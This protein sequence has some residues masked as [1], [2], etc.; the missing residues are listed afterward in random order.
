MSSVPSKRPLFRQEV[1]AF[2]QLDR[3]WG[4]VVPLQPMRTRVMVW[5]VIAA[6]AA[7]LVFVCLAKYARK[8]TAMGY[9][10]PAAGTAR[11]F[12]QQP[13]IVSARYVEQ[14]QLVQEGDPL[15]AV[16]TT[17]I[18]ANGEDV[19]AAILASLAQQKEQLLRQIVTE[20]RRTES[21]RERLQAQ[22]QGIESELGHLNAQ[23][24]VQRERIRLIER[25]V[26]SGAA[27]ATRGLVSELDQRRREEALLEQRLA[28]NA[29]QRQV[30]TRENQ[31]TETR[32]A[33]EQLPFVQAEKIQALRNNLAA[34]EQRAAEV[35]GRRAYIVRAPVAG[36]VA[37]VQATVGQPADPQRLLVQI[38]PAGS[39]L[40][41]ELFIPARA[42]GFIEVG[43]PVRIL[44]E[45]FP[46]QHFGS[47]R[48]RIESVSQAMLTTA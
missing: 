30:V 5:F 38:V 45:A 2:Q 36:R 48:G 9:L 39:P 4:R 15:V 24:A 25:I 17:Q 6:A 14:G 16:A 8:E 46:Y 34:A 19:N 21:E 26:S 33:L 27:L 40:R 20:E 42:I 7:I 32:F 22:L 29:L 47:Y 43:Q 18:A 11:V 13:G 1:V 3:Q 35:D 37:S 44:Y 12:P 23:L 10:A 41:A 28:L 31:R